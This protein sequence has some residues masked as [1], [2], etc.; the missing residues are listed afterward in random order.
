[1]G[2]QAEMN[3]DNLKND[4]NPK[5]RDKLKNET[6]TLKKQHPTLVVLLS[7]VLIVIFCVMDTINC[8]LNVTVLFSQ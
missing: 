1:M 6:V 3:K 7:I 4:E 8:A 2:S 5:H